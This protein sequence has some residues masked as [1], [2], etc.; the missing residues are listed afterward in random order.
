MLVYIYT[1]EDYA[2]PFCHLVNIMKVSILTQTIFICMYFFTNWKQQTEEDQETT[3]GRL[4]YKVFFSNI[5]N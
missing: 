2:Y 1:A 3:S 5:L 4:F